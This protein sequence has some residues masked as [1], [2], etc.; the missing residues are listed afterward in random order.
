MHS[1]KGNKNI[2][3][4]C[5]KQNRFINIL[6]DACAITFDSFTYLQEK[7][8]LPNC[9]YNVRC[10]YFVKRYRHINIEYLIINILI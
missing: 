7:E 9:G 4:I 10:V 3:G 5:V 2:R 6:K 1:I 8:S